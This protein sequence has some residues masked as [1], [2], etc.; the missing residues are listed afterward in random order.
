MQTGQIIRSSSW[1]PVVAAASTVKLAANAAISL[2]STADARVEAARI[3]PTLTLTSGAASVRL[4]SNRA[5]PPQWASAGA[6]AAVR[7]RKPKE[8][9]QADPIAEDEDP[10]AAAAEAPAAAEHT[11]RGPDEVRLEI[12]ALQY[13]ELLKPIP[14]VIRTLGERTFE[15]E[16][17]ELNISTTGSSLTGAFL[18]MKEQIITIFDRYRGK[19]VLNPEQQR[20]LAAFEQYVGG[21]RRNWYPR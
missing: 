21:P 14:V 9:P 20:Q 10:A 18:S 12:D 4:A 7:E 2:A 13:Y 15:A 8:E 5:R 19:K 3:P 16:V 1:A 17:P 11:P 6:P